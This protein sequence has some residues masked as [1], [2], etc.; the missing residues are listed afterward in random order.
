MVAERR[1]RYI[2]G[3]EA[4]SSL[5]RLIEESVRE[6][7][8]L[9]RQFIGFKHGMDLLSWHK[10]TERFN[11]V[12]GQVQSLRRGTRTDRDNKS[13]EQ[14]FASIVFQDIAYSVCARGRDDSRVVFSPKKTSELWAMLYPNSKFAHHPFGEETITNIYVPDGILVDKSRD[15]NASNSGVFKVLEYTLVNMDEKDL[16]KKLRSIRIQQ[17]N[18]PELFAQAG[19]QFVTPITFPLPELKGGGDKVEFLQLPITRIQFGNFIR[20]LYI[21]MGMK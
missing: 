18:F 17:K 5:P 7:Q 1:E 3:Q 9:Q 12:Y 16:E 11:R 21:G 15:S 13:L 10:K 6:T 4:L 8:D 2:P 19:I 14:D 20:D